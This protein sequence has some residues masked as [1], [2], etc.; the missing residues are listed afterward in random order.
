MG[1]EL[2]DT[3]CAIATPLGQGGIGIVRVSGDQALEISNQLVRLRSRLPLQK[4]SSHQLYL[5]DLLEIND[6]SALNKNSPRVIDE[7]LVVV[8]QAPRSFTGE[9]VVELHCHGGPL[10]LQ[11]ACDGLVTCGARLAEPGEF[12][13]RAFL[14]G[15]I[16]LTQ[17]EAVLDTIQAKT[18]QS[19]RLAQGQLRGN[20]ST[21]VGA[22]RDCLINLLA[23]VEAAI[24]FSEEGLS[25]ISTKDLEADLSQVAEGIARFI[26]EAQDGIIFREGVSAAIIGRPNVGKSSLLNALSQSNRAIVT[27]VP[28]TTRDIVEENAEYS[29][30]SRSVTGYSWNSTD[31]RSG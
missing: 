7:V 13:K 25:F 5:A 12:T 14:N 10:I 24:D 22:W 27:N 2:H 17:A 23:H 20:L 4:V 26:A 8:M 19:L 6:Q 1:T 11:M 31:Q 29:R 28:G 9:S 21:E 30:Y 3:I 16:D 18:A 15:K